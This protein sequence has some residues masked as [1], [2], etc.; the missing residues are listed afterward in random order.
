MFD[1]SNS[2]SDFFFVTHTVNDNCVF[3]FNFNGFCTSQ[4][5]HSYVF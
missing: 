3:F 2:C 1:L 5:I 4:L